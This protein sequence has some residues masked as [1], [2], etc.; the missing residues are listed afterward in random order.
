M[1]YHCLKIN[2]KILKLKTD[3]DENKKNTSKIFGE[4]QQENEDFSLNVK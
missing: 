4:G 3:V 2:T 1:R